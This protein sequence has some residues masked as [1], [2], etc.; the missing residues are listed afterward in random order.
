MIA[1]KMRTC[2]L[3]LYKNFLVRKRHWKMGLFVEFAIPLLL[4]GSIW[5]V[6]NLAS[7]PSVERNESIIYPIQEKSDFFPERGTKIYVVPDNPFVTSYMEEVRHCLGHRYC[8]LE[9]MSISF[10]R[11][12][13]KC[14]LITFS[15]NSG[16]TI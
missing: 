1:E 14:I 3:L 9:S 7:H 8:K 13:I 5:E 16:Q 15:F 10:T 6:R 2:K 12:V 11:K 4:L